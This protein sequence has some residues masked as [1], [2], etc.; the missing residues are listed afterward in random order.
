MFKPNQPTAYKRGIIEFYGL[1]FKVTPDVLIPRFET[2]QLVKEVINFVHKNLPADKPPKILDVGTGSGCIAI[3]LAKSLPTAKITAID[4]SEKALQIAKENAKTHQ[5]ENQITF[6][7]SDLL[8]NLIMEKSQPNIIIANLPYIPTERIPTLDS[9]VKD[10]EPLIALDGGLDG[11]DIYR[12]L[13][14][15]ITEHKL[16]PKLIIV[17]IDDTHKKIAVEESRRYFPQ[18]TAEI[19][20]D[21]SN[22]DRLLQIRSPG[23][24]ITSQTPTL[25][26]G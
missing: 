10:F 5:V 25:T 2:E 19:K 6:I 3:A 18:S 17:E 22:L 4:I 26:I 9:S 1:T 15:Q 23:E 21:A 11:F 7:H 12:K 14:K 16:T 24:Q 13:F 8:S 20:K